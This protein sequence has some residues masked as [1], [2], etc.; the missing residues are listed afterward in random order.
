MRA[1]IRREC[2]N[3]LD[4]GAGSILL[5]RFNAVQAALFGLVPLADG[6]DLAIG[7][8]QPEAVLSG[9]VGVDLKL[10]MLLRGKSRD[11]LI[12][13]RGHRR[14]FL[15]AGNARAAGGHTV[16]D[17]GGRDDLAVGCLEVEYVTGLC[18]FNYELAHTNT[19]NKID[20]SEKYPNILYIVPAAAKK[21]AKI[22]LYGVS[23]FA[24][25]LHFP[26][27]AAIM[28]CGNRMI[29]FEIGLDGIR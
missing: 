8:F 16:V 19:S 7:G 25:R 15:N 29:F 26:F 20:V 10:G 1:N 13:D 22:F 11:S 2:S 4:F 18:R 21:L 9:L 28:E 27:S 17:L 6:N 23:G 14:V 5:N 3:T 24:K 12:L